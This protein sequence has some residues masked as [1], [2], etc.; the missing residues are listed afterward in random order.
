M[1][2]ICC[3]HHMT[4]RVFRDFLPLT[5]LYS[6]RFTCDSQPYSTAHFAYKDCAGALPQLDDYITE[7]RAMS[8]KSFV[9]STFATGLRNWPL[10]PQLLQLTRRYKLAVVQ[11][12]EARWPGAELHAFDVMA[13]SNNFRS[14]LQQPA[15]YHGIDQFSV[16][17]AFFIAECHD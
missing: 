3:N 7:E 1:T 8:L 6:M 12:M 9:F 13:Y 2:Y 4:A 16:I 14:S 10:R 5:H 11:A 15:F 17:A